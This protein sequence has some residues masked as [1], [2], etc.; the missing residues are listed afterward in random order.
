MRLDFLESGSF[1][2]TENI[3]KLRLVTE[4]LFE[5]HAGFFATQCKIELFTTIKAYKISEKSN[6]SRS[7]FP[8]R[9][10]HLTIDMTGIYKEN[11]ILTTLF[12]FVKKPQRARKRNGIEHVRTNS[13]NNIHCTTFDKLA[14]KFLFGRAGIR[15]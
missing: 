8:V 11:C 15:G 13:D 1:A 10:I 6:L 4:N 14:A 3:G 12:T 5:F 7:P 2:E 9:T